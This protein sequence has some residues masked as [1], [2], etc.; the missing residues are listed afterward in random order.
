MRGSP[1]DAVTILVM[2][3]ITVLLFVGVAA[4]MQRRA[5]DP[6]VRPRDFVE[7]KTL[8]G[9]RSPGPKAKWLFWAMVAVAVAAPWVDY[10]I[11]HYQ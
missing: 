2:N 4:Y 7:V 8:P 10:L 11:L 6:N 3:A 1:P 5:K 9:L